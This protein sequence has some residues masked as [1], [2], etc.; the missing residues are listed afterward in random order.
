MKVI[1]EDI[2]NVKILIQVMDEVPE[3][4][5][6]EQG[7]RSTDLTGISDQIEVTY[8]KVKSLIRNI[9]EDIGSEMKNINSDA[10]PSRV[11]VEFN[12]GMS[13]Q[14]GPIWILSSKG[15]YLLKA[16][17]IWDFRSPEDKNNIDNT[18]IDS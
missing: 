13:A 10:L 5:G 9:A 7:E 2:G 16:K 12:I 6:Q 3:L 8:S 17:M 1:A 15:E 14:A 11:E 18:E 4:E